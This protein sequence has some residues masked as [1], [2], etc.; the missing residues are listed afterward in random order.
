VNLGDSMQDNSREESFTSLAAV[1]ESCLCLHATFEFEEKKSGRPLFKRC[2][3]Q[4][5]TAKPKTKKLD[6]EL[7]ITNHAL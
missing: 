2:V 7:N 6:P 3:L 5:Q 1:T 4:R